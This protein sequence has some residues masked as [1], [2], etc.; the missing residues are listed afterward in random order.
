MPATSYAWASG[1]LFVGFFL[2]I[3]FSNLAVY[4]SSIV[5]PQSGQDLYNTLSGADTDILTQIVTV[6][7]TFFSP[8]SGLD[9]WV[10]LLIFIPIGFGIIAFLTPFIN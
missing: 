1:A 10:Y 7:S 8:C 2:L 5:C 3:I 4:N 9:W 6:M